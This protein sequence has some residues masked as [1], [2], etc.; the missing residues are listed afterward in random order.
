MG[1]PG[2]SFRGEPGESIPGPRGQ[3][4]L[5]GDPAYDHSRELNSE[6]AK[7]VNK[8]QLKLFD[9]INESEKSISSRIKKLERH[10][11]DLSQKLHTKVKHYI[12][13]KNT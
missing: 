9:N 12:T 13:N 6:I 4:G 8:M 3:R 10:F 11:Y 1:P 5:P 2:E 7:L